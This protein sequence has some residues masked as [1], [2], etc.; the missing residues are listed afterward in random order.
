M[1]RFS[2]VNLSR[3]ILQIL[4][5][6]LAAACG[7]APERT[8]VRTDD[9]SL[10]MEQPKPLPQ[11]GTFYGPGLSEYASKNALTP[12]QFERSIHFA[13]RRS[14]MPPPSMD[15]LAREYAARFA[16][17]GKDPLPTVVRALARHCGYWGLPRNQLSLTA[18]TEAELMEHLKRV[19]DDIVQGMVAVGAVRHPD[20]RV[21]VS[22]LNP[23][24]DLIL[25]PTP[26]QMPLKIAGQVL[27]TDGDIEVW[28]DHGSAQPS[29][30]IAD[31]GSTGQFN[32]TMPD[33]TDI[34]TIEITRK[35][36]DFR[37][38]IAL[39][40]LGQRWERYDTEEAHQVKR[41]DYDMLRGQM[42]KRINAYRKQGG[43]PS[44]KL[45]QRLLVPLDDWL[46]RL[47][48]R[49]GPATP[50]GLLDERGWKYASVRY[51]LTHGEDG[52][53]A[54]DLFFETPTGKGIV[55]D[56]NINE[57]AVGLRAFPHGNGV[58]AVIVGLERFEAKPRDQLIQTL[59]TETNSQRG[60]IGRN[61]LKN[62]QA[63]NKLVQPI[64]EKVLSGELPWDQAMED[65]IKTV[66]RS[67]LI[68]GEILIGGF[69][70]PNLRL[71]QF[72]EDDAAMD[73]FGQAVG[74]GV[75]GGL[76]PGSGSPRYIVL[77]FVSRKMPRNGGT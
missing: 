50:P 14:V 21:T 65:M 49:A 28:V 41:E 57:V 3:I 7:S 40:Q 6:L 15:C 4:V 43:L 77:Y 70:V 16:A 58:D 11:P 64:A 62:F 22:M 55:L 31:A 5:M 42:E 51:G 67:R 33:R 17:D 71:V 68:R 32:V 53:R 13:L 35:T 19:P 48:S 73:P 74:F 36:G 69:T 75:A 34:R 25:E 39:L 63:L 66:K 59:V 60:A 26:R 61:P 27:R 52:Q 2:K 18:R 1:G 38:T 72:T 56:P 29:L 10:A 45:Q 37:T 12:S 23:P 46:S 20:G 8:S 9:S 30:L 44:L 47:S 24:R 76:L 54:V